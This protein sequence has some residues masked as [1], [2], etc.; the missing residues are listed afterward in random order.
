MN[1]RIN[2][3]DV[4]GLCSNATLDQINE[5]TN[6]LLGRYAGETEDETTSVILQLIQQAS[7]ELINKKTRRN[8]VCKNNR[9]QRKAN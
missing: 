1:F 9:F 3:Y 2:P 7:N 5:K 4:L 6:I 8:Y